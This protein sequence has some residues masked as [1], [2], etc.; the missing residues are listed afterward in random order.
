MLC[1]VKGVVIENATKMREVLPLI[2]RAEGAP[3]IDIYEAYSHIV[4]E[5]KRLDNLSLNQYV[6]RNLPQIP[7]AVLSPMPAARL[8]TPPII[9]KLIRHITRKKHKP[10]LVN[11]IK[12]IKEL[13]KKPGGADKLQKY[14]N[15]QPSPKKLRITK[16]LR[17][18]IPQFGRG[19]NQTKKLSNRR[20]THKK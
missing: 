14:I 16:A 18:I 8:S 20:K 10:Q 4:N 3:E 17:R 13:L 7:E 2:I 9:K 1:D 19:R 11:I 15:K 6:L 12:K 5:C